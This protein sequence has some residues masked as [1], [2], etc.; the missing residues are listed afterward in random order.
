[1]ILQGAKLFD[2]LIVAIGVNPAKKPMFTLDERINMLCEIVH[3]QY[4]KNVEVQSF[5]NEF[6]VE[7]ARQVDANYLLRGIR[8]STDYAFEHNMRNV[9]ADIVG[10][11]QTTSINTVFLIPPREVCE[12][13]SSLVKGL[14]GPKNWEGIVSKYVPRGVFET[15]IR[16]RE[17]QCCS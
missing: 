16:N 10:D 6:L 13:S 3:S 4:L 17:V 2:K 14:I 12:I 5:Q 7:Y 8:S 1:M 15:I 9:N 11:W